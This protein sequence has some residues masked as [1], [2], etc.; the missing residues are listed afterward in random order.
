MDGLYVSQA[1]VGLS[2]LA[3]VRSHLVFRFVR[4]GTEELTGVERGR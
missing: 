1:P 4:P 2:W 3:R